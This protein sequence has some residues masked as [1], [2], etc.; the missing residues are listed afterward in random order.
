MTPVRGSCHQGYLFDVWNHMSRGMA[1]GEWQRPDCDRWC[2]TTSL[3][4]SVSPPPLIPPSPVPPS[5]SHHPHSSR[6]PTPFPLDRAKG[7]GGPWKVAKWLY[8]S[9]Y[10]YLYPPTGVFMLGSRFT[11]YADQVPRRRTRRVFCFHA[12]Y[13]SVF[14]D[15]QQAILIERAYGQSACC[16]APGISSNGQTAHPFIQHRVT[17]HIPGR[18]RRWSGSGVRWTRAR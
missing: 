7:A 11:C 2:V 8:R 16:T 3:Q 6:A 12:Q 5:S 1:L 10:A 9:R 15:G 17:R 18:A 4:T 13:H 14:L